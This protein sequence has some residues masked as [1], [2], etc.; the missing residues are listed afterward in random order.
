MEGQL[1]EV[2]VSCGIVQILSRDATTMGYF[3]VLLLF[4]RKFHSML[5]GNAAYLK[6]ILYYG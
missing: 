4:I 6:K 1:I 5:K 2:S 3:I